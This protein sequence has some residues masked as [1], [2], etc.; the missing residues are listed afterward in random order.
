MVSAIFFAC[1]AHADAYKCKDDKGKIS[2]QGTP[3]ATDTVG[4]VNK[5]SDAPLSDQIRARKDVNDAIEKEQRIIEAKEKR[6]VLA[7]KHKPGFMTKDAYGNYQDSNDC[8]QTKDAF[9]NYQESN[10]CSK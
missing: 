10:G 5:V 2:Y 3:C 4:R 1:Q 8:Y 9:G 6:K 7:A